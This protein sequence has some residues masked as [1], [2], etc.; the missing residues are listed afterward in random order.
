MKRKIGDGLYII[1]ENY[2]NLAW[3]LLEGSMDIVLCRS[4]HGKIFRELGIRR[5]EVLGGGWII[6]DK[7]T[8]VSGSAHAVSKKYRDYVQG[9]ISAMYRNIRVA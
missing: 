2:N 4:G 7:I 1:G 6:R 8:F 3:I 9:V 5:S